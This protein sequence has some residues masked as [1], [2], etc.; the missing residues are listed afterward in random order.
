MSVGGSNMDGIATS[1]QQFI[2]DTAGKIKDIK[3]GPSEAEGGM[4]RELQFEKIK[5]QM[6]KISQIQ[7]MLSNTLKMMHEQGMQ[8]IRNAKA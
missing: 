4:S 2:N 5:Q 1:Y 7:D 3:N 8:A 6:Q